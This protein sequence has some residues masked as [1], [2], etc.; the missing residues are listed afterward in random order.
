[1]DRSSTALLVRMSCKFLEERTS[2]S[3]RMQPYS[4]LFIPVELEEDCDFS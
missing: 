1:M 2:T 4:L 3:T